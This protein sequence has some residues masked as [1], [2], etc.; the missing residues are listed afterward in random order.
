[1]GNVAEILRGQSDESAMAAM[2][3]GAGSR[4]NATGH[5]R[6]MAS[7]QTRSAKDF[8]AMLDADKDGQI[9]TEEF[10]ALDVNRC[11]RIACLAVAR[12]SASS[13]LV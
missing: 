8:F 1:M 7:P 10:K 11:V 12:S 2:A 13:H 4:P 5:G 3:D 9:S 6:L